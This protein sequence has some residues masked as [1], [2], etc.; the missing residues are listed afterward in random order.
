MIL[1][2]II[3]LV[4]GTVIGGLCMRHMIILGIKNYKYERP[5]KYD[6]ED[7]FNKKEDELD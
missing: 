2:F 7:Y 4:L 5:K 1:G 6:F 3:G